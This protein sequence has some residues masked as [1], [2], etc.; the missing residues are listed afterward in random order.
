MDKSRCEKA[1]KGLDSTPTSIRMEFASM[2][3]EKKTKR[4]IDISSVA[5]TLPPMAPKTSLPIAI[6]PNCHNTLSHSS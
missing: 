6:Q 1:N 3:G 4:L 5:K 2:T